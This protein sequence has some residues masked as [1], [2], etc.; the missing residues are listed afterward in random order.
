MY[1]DMAIKFWFSGKFGFLY[2]F[3][4]LMSVSSHKQWVKGSSVNQISLTPQF[5]M[6]K[7]SPLQRWNVR[8][9]PGISEACHCQ[10]L[11]WLV[12]EWHVE[13]LVTRVKSDIHYRNISVKNNDDIG[14]VDYVLIRCRMGVRNSNTMCSF[15]EEHLYAMLECQQCCLNTKNIPIKS[16]VF[17][18]SL[19]Y[20]M[21]TVGL[22]FRDPSGS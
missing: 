13:T 17:L 3:I 16:I 5:N 22:F 15:P 11:H 6:F 21:F 1:R 7:P 10:T 8:K 20:Q 19:P 4:A 2:Q 14:W 12:S 18:L 9:T